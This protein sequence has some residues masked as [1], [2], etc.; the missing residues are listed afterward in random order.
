ME[1]LPPIKAEENPRLT[2]LDRAA[3]AGTDRQCRT[4]LPA[5]RARLPQFDEATVARP[6]PLRRMHRAVEQREGV[7]SDPITR[8]FDRLVTPFIKGHIA[9]RYRTD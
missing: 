9:L 5:L 1:K 2:G 7:S 8:V 3:G 6:S 4:V